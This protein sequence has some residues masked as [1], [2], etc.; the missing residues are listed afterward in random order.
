ME[1]PFYSK[2]EKGTGFGLLTTYKIIHEH[3]G[4]ISFESKL[5]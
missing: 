3:G 5:D 4:R 1:L 2:K